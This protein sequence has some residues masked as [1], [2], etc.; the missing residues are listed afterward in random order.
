[1]AILVIVVIWLVFDRQK[2]VEEFKLKLKEEARIRESLQHKADSIQ[3]E[4][5][6]LII[7]Y[8]NVSDAYRKASEEARKFE[9]KYETEKK[10]KVGILTDAAY[11][12]VINRLYP[13]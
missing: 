11:D 4:I 2:T 1:M 12:S 8:R 9:K 3:K 10:R 13:R 7:H 5:D 6:L